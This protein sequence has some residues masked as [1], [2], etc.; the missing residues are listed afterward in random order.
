MSCTLPAWPPIML[1]LLLPFWPHWMP[2]L[3]MSFGNKPFTQ[4]HRRMVWRVVSRMM[5]WSTW[6]VLSKME[7]SLILMIIRRQV[8]AKTMSLWCKCQ[9]QKAIPSGSNSWEHWEMTA[10][11]M[12]PLALCWGHVGQFAGNLHPRFGTVCLANRPARQRPNSYRSF[13]TRTYRRQRAR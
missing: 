4:Q 1:R 11:P 10:W 12:A 9:V 6:P 13:Q 5:S 7:E 8:S 3:W 2:L